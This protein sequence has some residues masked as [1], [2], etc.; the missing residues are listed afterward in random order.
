MSEEELKYLGYDIEKFERRVNNF[1]P[2]NNPNEGKREMDELEEM[3]RKLND[4][5]DELES[6]V[7]DS[8]NMGNKQPF[9]GKIRTYRNTM[10]N[11]QDTLNSKRDK[12]Q[13]AY[14]RELLIEGK[15]TG[16]DKVEAERNM[17]MDEHKEVNY[18]GDLINNIASN[19]KGA[20]ENMK[21]MVT[22][23]NDQGNQMERVQQHTENADKLVV[24]TNKMMSSMERRQACMKF[25]GIIA[26]VLMGI[27]DIALLVWKL[28]R[29]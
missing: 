7:N 28:T 18:Q 23:L 5:I 4:K 9:L 29:D 8:S 13:T 26:A 15:L 2:N 19:I 14:N 20:G 10:E 21:N 27:V 1:N 3:Q 11:I 6:D 25:G 24:D 22:E 17:I 12:W 16:A